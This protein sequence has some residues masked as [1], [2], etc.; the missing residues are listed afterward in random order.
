MK[1]SR[2]FHFP[3]ITK[4]AVPKHSNVFNINKFN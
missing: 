1:T 4:L 3:T 2:I